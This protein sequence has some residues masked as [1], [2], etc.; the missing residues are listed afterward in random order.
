MK[1]IILIVI[2]TASFLL[3]KAQAILNEV[4]TDPGAGKHEFFELYNTSTSTAPLS[5][6]N[7]TIV[8]FFDLPGERGF[9]VMDLP[10]MTVA[11]KGYFVG[12]SAIT[13]NYQGVVNSS[14]SDFSWNS[15]S[16]TSNNGYLKKWVKKT[17]NL[18]DGNPDYDEAP[19]AANFNDFFYRR[20]GMGSSYT[21]FVYQ[22][23]VL[24]NACIFGTG[25][26]T[27]VIPAIVA[28]PVLYIDMSGTATDFSIDFSTYGT[29]PVESVPQEAGS[30]NGFI[31][32]ADGLCGGWTKSSAGVQHTP[33]KS[34]G[35]VDN[36]LGAISATALVKRGT[37]ATGSTFEYDV[38]S[39]PINSFP[40]ELQV[41]KD[42]GTKMAVLDGS[43]NYI[44]SN[45][46]YTVNDGPFVTAFFPY[47]MNMLLVL[48]TNAGCIDKVMFAPNTSVLP[49]KLNNFE[50]NQSNGKIKLHWSVSE[51]ENAYKFELEKSLDGLNFTPSAL[52]FSSE[53]SGNENYE[54]SEIMTSEKIF[55]RLRMTDKSNKVNYSKTLSFQSIKSSTDNF[56]KVFNNPANDRITFS[57][58]LH[59]SQKV[60]AKIID[61]TGRIYVA[62]R[63][64]GSQG[65]SNISMQLAPAM[66]SGIYILN[67]TAGAERYTTKFVKQ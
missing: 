43:D 3:A 36:K 31:R 54:Y 65:V 53:K 61:L 57:I 45:F 62:Q 60:D 27:S 13:Y 6:D 28:M 37:P 26:Y 20:T 19:L 46:E 30:D 23:G 22:N 16:F 9:Y 5:V 24:V 25:G 51:N 41:Y 12:S 35:I 42:N 34:N 33:Q 63:I 15:A 56:I 50:G 52:V 67:V 58:E 8:T 18:A 64:N 21:I 32:T 10:N 66:Q 11:S 59:Q 55:Y 17:V 29:I 38:I 40:I 7:Y 47:D 2:C 44:E 48:K 39:A 14:A 1:K 4:Y 49:V